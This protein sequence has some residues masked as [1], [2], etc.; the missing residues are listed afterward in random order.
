MRNRPRP[1]STCAQTLTPV[2]ADCP[3]C[4]HRLYADYATCR[5]VTTLDGITHLTIQVRRCHN[6]AC[7]RHR[8]PYHP[9]AEP[10]FALPHHEF[11][12]DVIALVGRLRHAEHR[13]IPEV[14]ARKWVGHRR[15]GK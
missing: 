14:I 12:L 9:E 13:S 1:R 2:L 10:H 11:G 15:A 8:R 5:T 3:V 4:Q 6:P 7:S